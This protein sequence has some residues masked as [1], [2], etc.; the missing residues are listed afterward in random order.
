MVN[1]PSTCDDPQYRY[2]MPRLVSK[3]E[4]RGNGSKTCIVN[5]SDVARALHRPPQYTTKWFGCELGSMTTYTTKEGEGERAIINGHHDTPIFQTMLDKFIEKYVLCE[6]CHLPEIDMNVKKGVIVARCAACGWAGDLDNNHKLAAFI[7]KNPPDESGNGVINLAVAGAAGGQTKDERRKEREEKRKAKAEGGAD[8]DDGEDAEKPA[9]VQK[10]KKERSGE[11]KEKKEKKEKLDEDGN[12]IKREKK[13]KKERTGEK[14]EKKDRSERK[15]KKERSSKKED[16]PAAQ[17]DNDSDESDGEKEGEATHD[18]EIAKAVIG[19]MKEFIATKGGKA[20]PEDFFEELRMQQLAKLFDHKLR[21]Y[22]SLA[23]LMPDGTMTAKALG[24]HKDVLE[25]VL[26]AV[27]VPV[28]DVL[29]SFNA[30][31][32]VNIACVKSY[33]LVLKVIYDEEW[34]SEKDLLSYYEGAEESVKGPGYEAAAKSGAPFFK[35][36]KETE[37]SDEEE[38]DSEDSD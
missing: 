29:W 38:D 33:P 13:E 16:T 14:K 21:F 3:K 37:D 28:A 25:K 5:M 10:E 20:Q 6:Q 18:G 36:L 4:G 22:I 15:E 19:I 23:A 12:V 27:K 35:W 26:A 1:I 24:E 8:D 17:E 30:Y 32:S 34:A 7:S 9:R 11:K 31:L 2:K